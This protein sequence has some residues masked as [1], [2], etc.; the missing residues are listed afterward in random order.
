[1]RTYDIRAA[2]AIIGGRSTLPSAPALLYTPKS[3]NALEVRE[4]GGAAD[5]AVVVGLDQRAYQRREPAAFAAMLGHEVSHLELAATR[6]E[7]RTRILG[8][9][10][11]MFLVLLGFIDRRGNGSAPPL[12]GFAPVFDSTIYV[13]LGSQFIILVISSAIVL[14]VYSYFLIV[15]REHIHDFR[16]SQ[17][18]GTDGLA[19][20]LGTQR[21]RAFIPR[22]VAAARSFFT[23]HPNPAAR[24]QVLRGRDLILLSALLYPAVMLA[25]Q[26]LILLL[27]AGWRDF[28]GLS[29]EAWNVGLTVASG[30]FLYAV[31]RA[32]LTR[33]GLGLLLNARRYSF[34]LPVYALVGGA[35]TQIPRVVL[36]IVFGMRRDY[37]LGLILERISNGITAGAGMM[38]L[39][40]SAILASLA[41]LNAIR[42]AATGKE[43][44]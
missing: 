2:L 28:F 5:K 40:I 35:S 7:I 22:L 12:G 26:P 32:D 6:L 44:R 17:L 21:A 41:Y 23:L 4:R 9:L 18:A 31:L 29:A 20:A 19:D 36:E 16:G 3:A 42:I 13:Q 10:V 15:R 8:W 38:V 34:L 14:L 43:T 25:L 1:M 39:T 37:P 11:A 24:V 30:L 33:L 27:L